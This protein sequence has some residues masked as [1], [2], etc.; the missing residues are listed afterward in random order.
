MTRDRPGERKPDRRRRRLAIATLAGGILA[1]C[2]P[3][4][5]P[6]ADD[7]PPAELLRIHDSAGISIAP[8]SGTPAPATAKLGAALSR[9]LLDRDIPA[10]DKTASLGSYLLY[11]RLAQSR[12]R[13]G[14][15]KV[16]AY[17]RLYNAAGKTIGE[18]NVG[19][20][21][22]VRA[23]QKGDPHAIELLAAASVQ[24]LAPLIEEEAPMAAAPSGDKT[25]GDKTAGDKTVGD[26]TVGDKM[27]A[28]GD[29]RAAAK[30]PHKTAD[31]LRIAVHPLKGAP[32]DGDKSLAAAIATILGRQ[33]VAIVDKG[34]KADLTIDGVVSIT[35]VKANKQHVK[36]VWH[37][38]RA[39][40]AEIGTVGQENDVPNGLLDGPWG[41]LAYSVA[42]AANDGLLQLLARAGPPPPK[43]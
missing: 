12:P 27:A 5:H 33:D 31:R 23:W 20:D 16:T 15:A 39:D 21:A 4:P 36:I 9:A 11:G 42:I 22:P 40:G 2:Q 41:D 18:R 17:W 29:D 35:P 28:K 34:Q 13:R 6:F 30:E 19:I 8:I 1:G 26:K 32:G 25:A 43:S 14:H 37:L 3:L 7:R 24:A 38:R 10:S